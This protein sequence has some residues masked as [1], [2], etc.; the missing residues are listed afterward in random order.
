MVSI[1]SMHAVPSKNSLKE[2]GIYTSLLYNII[3]NKLT[4]DNMT[5]II[6]NAIEIIINLQQ[7][8]CERVFLRKAKSNTAHISRTHKINVKFIA[9]HSYQII[10][11]HIGQI[12][13]LTFKFGPNEFLH[14]FRMDE[15]LKNHLAQTRTSTFCCCFQLQSKLDHTTRP[16]CG[17]AVRRYL[18]LAQCEIFTG[19]AN[20]C[21]S[22][23]LD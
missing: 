7:L 10:C 19:V 13:L 21:S 22:Q 4:I 16:Y 5:K 8:G 17:S 9:T 1:C 12:E 14:Y 11:F 18:I 20:K 15:V 2:F 3:Y 6:I 23:S